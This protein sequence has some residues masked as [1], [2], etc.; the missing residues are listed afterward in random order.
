MCQTEAE[1]ESRVMNAYYSESE[2]RTQIGA[3]FVAMTDL[4][5][6]PAGTRGRVQDVV[7]DGARGWIVRVRWD[8][9]PKR[10]EL[11][12]QV[13]ELSFNVPWREKRREAEF[14]KCEIEQLLKR[15]EELR[16]TY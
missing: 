7:E 11:L 10:T 15:V 2:A 1:P 4:P 5:D 9:P 13:G 16:D 8:L 3:E 12:A 14:S 6:I